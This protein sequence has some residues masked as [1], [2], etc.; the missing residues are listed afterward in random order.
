MDDACKDYGQLVWQNLSAYL[1][2]HR[3]RP[4]P[5]A[6]IRRAEPLLRR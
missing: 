1:D 5:P 2:G 3:V 4:C 6:G